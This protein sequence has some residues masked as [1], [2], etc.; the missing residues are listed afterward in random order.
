M[1]DTG[2][3]DRLDLTQ[4]RKEKSKQDWKHGRPALLDPSITHD[5]DIREATRIFSHSRSEDLAPAKRAI[6]ISVAKEE[7]TV[8]TDGSASLSEDHGPQAR[9]GIWSDHEELIRALR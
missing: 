8:Y 7:I 2:L 5:G 3:L 4:R 6:P 1:D 9:A